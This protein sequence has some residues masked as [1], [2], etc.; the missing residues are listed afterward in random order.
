MNNLQLKVS[1]VSFALSNNFQ[2]PSN[3]AFLRFDRHNQTHLKGSFYAI[4]A[5]KSCSN[6]LSFEDDLLSFL[7]LESLSTVKHFTRL[8]VGDAVFH[9][10]MYERVSRRNSSTVTYHQGATINYGQIEVFFMGPVSSETNYCGAV[11]SPMLRDTQGLYKKHPVL[12]TPAHHIVTLK[13]PNNIHFVM[14]QLEN[15]IDVCS[16]YCVIV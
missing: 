4:G 7:G 6:R 14:V 12:G 11:I 5:M 3:F 10:K 9:S 13:K 2:C 15:I 16:L 8:Q 1:N